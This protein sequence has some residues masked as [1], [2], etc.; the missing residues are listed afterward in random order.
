MVKPDATPGEVSADI[1]RSRKLVHRNIEAALRGADEEP[2]LRAAHS[3][4]MLWKTAE[5]L[6][7]S[8]QSDARPGEAQRLHD[9]LRRSVL[10]LFGDNVQSGSS[11][12]VAMMICAGASHV[13][14]AV[15]GLQAAQTSGKG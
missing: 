13:A 6:I 7:V 5:D 12:L 14:M 10:E 11:L 8:H 2:R 4:C 9:D 15:V 1:A 3:A